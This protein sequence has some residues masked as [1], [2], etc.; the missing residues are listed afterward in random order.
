MNPGAG[1]EA[2]RRQVRCGNWATDKFVDND[3]DA[4]ERIAR[5]EHDIDV[6]RYAGRP[7]DMYGRCVGLQRFTLGLALQGG[8]RLGAQLNKL[9][10]V[11]GKCCAK[12]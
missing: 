11:Q 8:P 5:H 6:V 3:W 7:V 4:N 1:V 9:H 10:S 12:V 2:D